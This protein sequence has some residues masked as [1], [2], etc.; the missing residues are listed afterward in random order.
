MKAATFS[1]TTENNNFSVIKDIELAK[2]QPDQLLVKTKAVGINPT[3][4]KH[5]VGFG[6][7]SII[8]SDASGIVEEVGSDVKGFSKGDIVSSFDHGNTDF[9]RGKFGDYYITCA[10]GTI[11]YDK[12]K[13]NVDK[14]LSVGENDP[15]N[16]EN[17]EAAAA[18]TLSLGT[19][20]ISFHHNLGIKYD[21]DAN[22]DKSILIWGG[23][24]ATGIYAIQVAKYIYG[25]NVI[26]TAS[27]KNI[28]LL[29]SYGADQVFDYSDEN[30]SSSIKESSNG[31]IY[32]ALD[33]VST[34][35]TLQ[36][37]YDSTIGSPTIAIDNLLGLSED[38]LSN[39]DKSRNIKFTQTLVYLAIEEKVEMMGGVTRP[40]DLI[41]YYDEFWFTILPKYIDQIRS[42][43][44]LTLEP[45]LES[46]NQG[47]T[48]SKEG[49]VSGGKIVFR[50]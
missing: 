49:K 16:L 34:P 7:Q 1:G 24:T 39:C 23:A 4:W 11:K 40:A 30:V 29:K 21:K 33:T 37:T 32:Y 26:T 25:L 8:G 44:L 15:S 35:N 31:K 28:D 19:V 43:K 42:P 36:A 22:K 3:D 20:A 14:V 2:I 6:I 10:R 38:S 12:S 27:S 5:V 17:F 13:F 48:L 46:V 41:Q 9:V 18:S 47:L 50:V 45:G